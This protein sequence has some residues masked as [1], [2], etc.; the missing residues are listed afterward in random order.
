MFFGHYTS[1]KAGV[2]K[3]LTGPVYT[4]NLILMCEE[5][6]SL[7][8]D[9]EPVVGVDPQGIPHSGVQRAINSEC[10]KRYSQTPRYPHTQGFN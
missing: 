3:L 8:L 1:E 10:K 4:F 2:S 7:P 6:Y 5:E 9:D